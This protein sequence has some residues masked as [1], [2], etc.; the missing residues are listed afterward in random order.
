MLEC[1]ATVYITHPDRG[2]IG[3]SAGTYTVLRGHTGTCGF[4]GTFVTR[5]CG[6]WTAD[7]R[8][9]A[10]LA[11]TAPYGYH[12]KKPDALR[13]V[14]APAR[15]SGPVACCGNHRQRCLTGRHQWA[16]WITAGELQRTPN[17]FCCHPCGGVCTAEENAERE[18]PAARAAS[19]AEH[20]SREQK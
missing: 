19:P 3:L 20:G 1:T 18:D 4:C 9:A 5:I 17:T 11:P 7:R 14:P 13:D 6:Q 12:A 2:C 16:I 10:C 8:D 15:G